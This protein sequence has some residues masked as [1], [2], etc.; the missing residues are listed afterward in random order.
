MVTRDFDVIRLC[1]GMF[2]TS[3]SLIRDLQLDVKRQ[4]ANDVFDF[5]TLFSSFYT[6]FEIKI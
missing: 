1:V 3:T 5:T 2:G 4:I 6:S